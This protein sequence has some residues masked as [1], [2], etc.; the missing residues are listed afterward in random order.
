MRFTRTVSKLLESSMIT[1]SSSQCSLTSYPRKLSWV[2]NPVYF[3]YMHRQRETSVLDRRRAVGGG[4]VDCG[5]VLSRAS[6]RAR[7]FS[8]LRHTG[9]LDQAVLSPGANASHHPMR[10]IR[11]PVRRICGPVWP[12]GVETR[13]VVTQRFALISM[14]AGAKRYDSFKRK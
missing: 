8:T 6:A 7:E 14:I 3:R 5:F 12:R 9:I 13:L 1:K 4:A 10:A 11:C 2:G